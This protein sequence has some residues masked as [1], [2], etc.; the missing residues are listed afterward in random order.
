MRAITDAGGTVSA[1]EYSS[2]SREHS[3]ICYHKSKYT[4]AAAEEFLCEDAA[5]DLLL[6]NGKPRDEETCVFMGPQIVADNDSKAVKRA[7]RTQLN[8]IGPEVEGISMF[9]T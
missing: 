8:I 7:I 1:E 2:F 5:R 4:T 9:L 3:G 6:K